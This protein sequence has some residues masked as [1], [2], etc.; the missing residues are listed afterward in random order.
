MS[1]GIL[2]TV[3]ILIAFLVADTLFISKPVE[4]GSGNDESGHILI[5]QVYG[6]GDNTDA[7]ISHSFIE[8]YNPTDKDVLLD[9]WSLQYTAEGNN[10]KVFALGGVIPTESSFLIRCF[11]QDGVGTRYTVSKYDMDWATRKISNN[12]F[13]IALVGP[14]GELA[15]ANPEY[16]DGIVDF[17]G[18]GDTDFG[19]GSPL[20]GISKQKAARRISATDTD[21]NPADFEVIDFRANRLS[22]DVLELV[23]PRTSSEGAWNPAAV[24]QPDP[25]TFS[26]AAG[27]YSEKFLLALTTSFTDSVIRYT[28]DGSE[29]T[30]K[31]TLYS[32]GIMVE[33]RTNELARLASITNITEDGVKPPE[34][35]IYKGTTVRARV[36]TKAGDPL[37]PIVTKSYFVHPGIF[38]KYNGLPII[39]IVTDQANLFDKK[40]GI[41]IYDNYRNRG[42]E[43]E[44]PAHIEFFEGD[45]NLAF[46]Q[47][48]GMRIHGLSSREFK[49]KSFRF[50]VKSNYGLENPAVEYD[51]FNGRAQDADGI[52]IT[53][54]RNFILRKCGVMN[55]EAL[56][57]DSLIQQICSNADGFDVATQAFRQCVAFID[58]EFWGLYNIRQRYD[59]RYFEDKYHLDRSKIQIA[60]KKS[61]DPDVKAKVGGRNAETAYTEMRDFFLN[62]PR[63]NFKSDD[64]YESAKL[65]VD[66]DNLI[67][68]M[69]A[70]TYWG[71][72]DW[73]I[74]NYFFWRYAGPPEEGNIY[75]DG[76]WRLA[77]LDFDLAWIIDPWN[78]VLAEFLNNDGT[79]EHENVDAIAMF[80]ALLE[81]P[82]F[83]EQFI[84]RYYYLMD[85]AFSKDATYGLISEMHESI[86]PVFAEQE[87]RYIFD[88]LE[89]TSGNFHEEV[90]KLK[91]YVNERPEA[92]RYHLEKFFGLAVE[93]GH[94]PEADT[95]NVVFPG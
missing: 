76:R 41:Y 59:E 62:T 17:V 25:L 81:N 58:G 24:K 55:N 31:S 86:K 63:E 52:P 33:D 45:G 32:K 94:Q 73:P 64:V 36:Y 57:K 5:Y 50:Y 34:E 22:N 35:A 23:R 48:M 70:Y 61:V 67:D 26:E 80:L 42:P 14:D 8:L 83:R 71:N 21:Y 69:I 6:R 78:S 85:T 7:S 93:D 39:S 3:A 91:N 47:D 49:Q 74:N 46:S 75:S 77:L 68:V 29:P 9:G 95:E 79:A 30:D 53:S 89:E 82:G 11:S 38:E 40:T 92:V 10:W 37:S 20:I 65:Y 54:Y 90:R 1:K 13:K 56:I 44:R 84:D 18:L 28:L 72:R 19:D 16:G 51:L 88:P 66:V 43:W 27:L 15:D 87:S 4:Y 60:E 12:G 2:A